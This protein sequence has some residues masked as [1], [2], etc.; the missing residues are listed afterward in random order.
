MPDALSKTIPIWCAVINLLLFGE[1]RER[2]KLRTPKDLV[3]TSEH[4]QIKAL[5]DGFVEDLKVRNIHV[6]SCKLPKLTNQNLSLDICSLRS[7]LKKPLQSF[8]VTPDSR[9]TCEATPTT[10]YHTI[11]CCTASRRVF[12]AEMTEG[13][14]I[15]GAG[16]DSEGWSKGLTPTLFWRHSEQLLAAS[17][18]EMM[19]LIQ[20]LITMDLDC[21][22]ASGDAVNIGPTRLFV[23]TLSSIAQAEQYDG[24]VICR[25]AGISKPEESEQDGGKRVL[26]LLCGD[27]KLGSRALRSQLPHIPPFIA[28]LPNADC[29]PKILFLCATGKDLSIGTAL[30]VLCLFFDDE[31]TLPMP[32]SSP[33]PRTKYCSPADSHFY[34]PFQ[35][36][37]HQ[38]VS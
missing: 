32:S 27:G 11:I 30:A 18:E 5:L 6:P 19:D 33:S 7:I 38:Y 36:R 1:N 10:K 2:H 4:A 28:S 35:L 8:W 29:A 37:C 31:C 22:A 21:N 26:N 23:G 12:G 15:Q 3:G 25:S 24:V 13:G 9:T 34:R 20:D 14:Y 17:E 16:D